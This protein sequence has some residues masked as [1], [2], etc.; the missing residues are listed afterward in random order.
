MNIYTY[1]FNISRVGASKVFARFSRVLHQFLFG[2]RTTSLL[3]YISAS[4]VR[5]TSKKNK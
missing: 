3:P 4:F 1:I 2:G 5:Y